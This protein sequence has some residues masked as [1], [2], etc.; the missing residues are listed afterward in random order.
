MGSPAL[1]WSVVTVAALAAAAGAVRLL[2]GGRGT[3]FAAGGDLLMGFAMAV[4]A[5]PATASWYAAYGLWWAAAFGLLGLAGIALAVGHTRARGRRAGRAWAH[6]VV[7]SLGMVLM[8]LAMTSTSSGPVLALGHG[9]GSTPGSTPGSGHGSGHGAA[10]TDAAHTDQ[11]TTAAGT[12]FG[13]SADVLRFVVVALAL[14]FLLSIV[15][16]VWARVRS[17]G[18]A[19][20]PPPARSGGRGRHGRRRGLGAPREAAFVAHVGMGAS[21]SAMLLTMVM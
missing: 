17:T 10:V 21:M 2:T 3:R 5:V 11:G 12:H 20:V 9:H 13:P 14:Y 1:S 8:T 7:G 18:P 4:M 15:T 6:L 19:A 16:S